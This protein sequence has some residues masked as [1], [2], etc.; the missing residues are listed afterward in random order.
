MASDEMYLLTFLQRVEGEP[1]PASI[2][3]YMVRVCALCV[4]E[5]GQRIM[6]IMMFASLRKKF[7]IR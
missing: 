7:N 2:S 5:L 3:K 6:E 1:S 4:H